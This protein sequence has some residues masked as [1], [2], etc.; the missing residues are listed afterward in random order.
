MLDSA[1]MKQPTLQPDFSL[2]NPKTAVSRRRRVERSK[3]FFR[4]ETVDQLDPLVG[5]PE[6]QVPLGHLARRVRD[7]VARLDMGDL[8]ERKSGLGRRAFN[9]RNI[10]AVLL[11]A[12]IIGIHYM[13]HVA[14]LIQTDAAFRLLTGGHAISAS[15]LTAFRRENGELFDSVLNQTI[16]LGF[17]EGLVDPEAL[18]IDGM[19]LRADASTKSVRTLERSKKRLDALGKKDLESMSPE[20]RAEHDAKVAKHEEAVTHCE[21]LGRTSYS[22]TNEMASLMKFPNGAAEPGHRF[23]ATATGGQERFVVGIL[24]NERPTDYGQLEEGL[25]DARTRLVAAGM[26]ENKRIRATADAGFLGEEDQ[27]FI[28]ANRETIDVIVPPP[29]EGVRKNGVI[30]MFRRSDFGRDELGSVVC[31]A[32]TPMKPPANMDKTKLVWTGNGCSD[33]PLKIR[34]TTSNKPRKFEVDRAKE[35]IHAEIERRLQEPGAK[36]AYAQR[37]YTIEPVFSVIEGAMRYRRA[38][39]RHWITVQAEAKLKFGAYNIT[40][41]FAFADKRE[42][43]QTPPR[44]KRRDYRR[45]NAAA[46]SARVSRSLSG[47]CPQDSRLGGPSPG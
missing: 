47:T 7:F 43:Q 17:Q 27:K 26:P 22:T 34:C 30:V 5:A 25:L 4:R 41:L 40:R 38:S 15:T 12:S 20:D 32:G 6:F 2:T 1:T 36:E 10:L 35:A 18:A 13:T 21:E 29:T 44:P 39:S 46:T 14:S 37:M 19:R 31:P 23:I 3:G 24:V 45:H 28:V 11:Y 9:P 8:A 42:A 33:C 16:Q